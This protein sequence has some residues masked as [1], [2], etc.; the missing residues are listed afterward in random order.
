[1]ETWETIPGWKTNERTLREAICFVECFMLI[2]ADWFKRHFDDL[3]MQ[4]F[5]VLW[6]DFIQ[7]EYRLFVLNHPVTSDCTPEY[8]ETDSLGIP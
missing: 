1:M 8:C 2:V 4:N 3:W 7:R 6:S 5:I